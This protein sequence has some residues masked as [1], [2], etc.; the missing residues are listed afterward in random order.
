MTK[1]PGLR[2]VGALYVVEFPPPP[3]STTFSL[4]DVLLGSNLIRA[5]LHDAATVLDVSRIRWQGR[6]EPQCPVFEL[7]ILEDG[8]P[9]LPDDRW[10]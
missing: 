7:P 8:F 4:G 2:A 6:S 3:L 10:R 1:S 9:L 5:D